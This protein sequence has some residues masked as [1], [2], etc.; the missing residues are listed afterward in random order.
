MILLGISIAPIVLILIYLNKRDKYEK[1]PRELLTKVLIFGALTVI[2]IYLIE[3]YL[4]NYW[5]AKYNYVNN[6]LYI[7]AYDAFIVAASTEEFFKY[8]VFVIIIWKNKNFNEKFDGIL[9]AA[10][11]S[12]GFAAIE[13]IMY[14]LGSGARTGFIRA[15][16]AIPA[17]TFFGITMGFFFALAKFKNNKYLWLSI[18]LI[19]PILMHGFYD[20]IL[21]SQHPTLLVFFI[22]FLILMLFVA[23]KQMKNLSE[24]SRFNPK[25]IS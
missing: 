10:F 1:E 14:V 7:A 23:F 24:T 17:H 9:Y 3:T 13:N 20:F 8:L 22:P 15:F 5:T 12:L 6:K 16:T 19:L 4:G 25:N 18:A 11:I 21:M 2:P